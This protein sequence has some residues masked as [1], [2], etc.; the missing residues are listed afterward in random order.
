MNRKQIIL[1]DEDIQDVDK[2]K[3]YLI[4]SFNKRKPKKSNKLYIN[5]CNIYNLY[6][7]L[8]E[9]ILDNISKLGYYKDYFHILYFS[10]NYKLNNYIYNLVITQ[11]TIDIGNLEPGKKIS[12]LGKWLPSEGSKINK[13]INFVDKFNSLFWEKGNKFTLRKKY[14][15][16]KTKLNEKLGTLESLM[17]TKQYEKINLNKVSYNA[18][19]RHKHHLITHEEL[20]PKFYDYEVSKLKKMSLFA[21]I[22]ELFDNK[23]DIKTLEYVWENQ[24]YQIPYLNALINNTICAIDLSKDMFTNNAHYLSIGIAL[25]VDK[26]STHKNSIIVCNNNRINFESTD[27]LLDKKNKLIK[28]SGPCRDIK[29]SYYKNIANN[30]NNDYVLLFVTNKF[31]NIDV[32]NKIL[33][34]IPYYNNNYDVVLTENGKHKKI[35]KYEETETTREKIGVIISCAPELRDMTNIYI[36][37]GVA[38]LWVFIKFCEVFLFK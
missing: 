33:Q 31:I 15:Q 36:I 11:I 28:Y 20:V 17:N 34:I 18:L 2:V 13:K 27:T 25:L 35:T 24:D 7:N 5:L 38:T 23:Y 22:K 19:Q 21:F 8:V 30:I 4:Q 29:A 3:S 12:T 26:L 37:L 1:A 16:L 10:T 32:P 9:S 14:R 6:P